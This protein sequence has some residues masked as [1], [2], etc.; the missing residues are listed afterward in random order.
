MNTM[1]D[2]RCVCCNEFH[3]NSILGAIEESNNKM[4]SVMYNM[5]TI[6]GNEDVLLRDK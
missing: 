6:N 3:T 4:I 1:I 5:T 2:E